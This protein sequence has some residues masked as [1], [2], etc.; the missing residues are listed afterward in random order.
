MPDQATQL[1][2]LVLERAEPEPTP[3][4]ALRAEDPPAEPG[5]AT[6]RLTRLVL[7]WRRFLGRCTSSVRR[8]PRTR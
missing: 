3:A 7:A 6:E 2:Q 5:P 1:R 4:D 8:S